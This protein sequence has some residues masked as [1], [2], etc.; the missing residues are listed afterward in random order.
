M[1]GKKTNKMN[2]HKRKEYSSTNANA[3]L[4]SP[5]ICLRLQHP[6]F[7]QSFYNGAITKLGY[8]TVSIT[9]IA[10]AMFIFTGYR[11]RPVIHEFNLIAKILHASDFR[12]LGYSQVGRNEQPVK[13]ILNQSDETLAF[14]IGVDETVGFIVKRD[15]LDWPDHAKN[16]CLV[17]Q[18]TYIGSPVI[19]YGFFDRAKEEMPQHDRLEL[20]SSPVPVCMTIKPNDYRSKEDFGVPWDQAKDFF[21]LMKATETTRVFLHKIV[22]VEN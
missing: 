5:S 19:F 1:N 4:N 10:V 8:F 3:I 14:E 6:L 13:A 22:F 18:A 17:V 16:L 11:I 7:S 20:K 2:S 15:A 9:L 12:T 21:F